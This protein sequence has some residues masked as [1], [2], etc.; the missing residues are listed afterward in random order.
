MS[1]VS[2][3]TSP[4]V[5][6]LYSNSGMDIADLQLIASQSQPIVNMQNQESTI[7][8]Q[9]QI[10]TQIQNETQSFLNSIKT[11]TSR[12]IATG[13]SIFDDMTATSSNSTIATATTSGPV[14]AQ[15][16]N[17]EVKTLPTATR[18]A[19]TGAVGLWMDGNTTMSQLGVTD[20][21][22]TVFSGGTAYSINAAGA[23]KVSDVLSRI[24]S[25]VPGIT[26]ATVV[27]GAIQLQYS[28]GAQISLGAS[29]GD[30]S[31]FLT[32]TALLTAVNDA[33]SQ[34]ITAANPISTIDQSQLLSS[35]AA[36]LTTPVTDG[37]FSVN[38]VSFD[39]TGKS[40][41]DIVSAINNNSTANVMANF[42]TVTNKLELTSKQ[43]GSTL[44]NL[45]NGTGNFLMP[46]V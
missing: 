43:T 9:Q 31:N 41:S 16:I 44:I 24:T 19:S 37:P 33:G 11:L 30:T 20:G 40:L 38:G 13:T 36:N 21:N 34:T 12:D 25:A 5:T 8:S 22:F 3:S 7:K 17:L 10:H 4:P 1:S 2:S 15:T 14:A 27:N 42:N 32:K 35:A 39:T 29:G 28:V 45:S 6:N 23:D 26:S 46:W 18:A